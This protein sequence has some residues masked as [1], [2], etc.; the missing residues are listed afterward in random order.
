[1]DT[2]CAFEGKGGDEIK[3]TIQIVLFASHLHS[4]HPS[5]PGEV[6]FYFSFGGRKILFDDSSDSLRLRGIDLKEN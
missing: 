4:H 2:G 5:S 3:M 1:M 6:F